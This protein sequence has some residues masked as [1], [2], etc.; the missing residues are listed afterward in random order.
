MKRNTISLLVASIAIV[1]LGVGCG[2]T[3]P[4]NGRTTLAPFGHQP[5][6]ELAHVERASE[7]DKANFPT[8]ELA[9]IAN[10]PTATATKVN[11]PVVPTVA[12]ATPVTGVVTVPAIATKSAAPTTQKP[13]QFG[14]NGMVGGVECLFRNDR[15]KTVTVTV[16]DVNGYKYTFDVGSGQEEIIPL[17]PGEY[18]YIYTLEGDDAVYP[19]LLPFP[20]TERPTHGFKKAQKAFCGGLRF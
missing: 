17:L 3:A 19:G 1:T 4:T 14:A 16:T 9:R 8:A 15:P 6:K 20:V 10:T 18:T 13:V 7:S 11:A 2:T 5:P 12:V